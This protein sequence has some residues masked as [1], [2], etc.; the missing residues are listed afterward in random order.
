MNDCFR[1]Q[2]ETQSMVQ[3]FTGKEFS[4]G[5]QI[6]KASIAAL[7]DFVGTPLPTYPRSPDLSS[8]A[9]LSTGVPLNGRCLSL[10]VSSRPG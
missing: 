7:L 10:G 3:G 2:R 9:L 6:E 4:T 5:V 8:G 1:K